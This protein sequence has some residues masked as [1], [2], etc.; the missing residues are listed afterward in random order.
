ML[1]SARIYPWSKMPTKFQLS[2][3]IPNESAGWQVA[4]MSWLPLAA[5]AAAGVTGTA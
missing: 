4:T 1:L 5:L 2:Y 3:Q